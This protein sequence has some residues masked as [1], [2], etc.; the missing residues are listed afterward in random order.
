MKSIKRVLFLFCVIFLILSIGG[1]Y[2]TWTYSTGAVYPVEEHLSI[3]IGDFFWEGSGNLPTDGDIGENHLLLIENIVNHG[4]H[5]L[6]SSNSY[7]NKQISARKNNSWISGGSR[8]TLGSM[9]VTQSG[10]LDEIFGLSSSNLSFL[11][12][13]R[14]S[15]QHLLF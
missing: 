2:A 5:G 4:E 11:I 1:A 7:L 12:K 3:K 8:D 9:A 14:T 10:E 6:N 13:F 15:Y